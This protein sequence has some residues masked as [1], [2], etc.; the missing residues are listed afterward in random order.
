MADELA[1]EKVERI[2][3]ELGKLGR[4]FFF[5][6]GIPLHV[7]TEGVSIRTKSTSI[8][9]FSDKYLVIKYPIASVST[10]TMLKEGS[11]ITVRYLDKGTVFAFQSDVIGIVSKPDVLF[12]SY[13]QRIEQ[14]SLRS[15]GRVDCHLP[16]RIVSPNAT[17]SDVLSRIRYIRN[18]RK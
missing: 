16:C 13:P 11:R 3:F 2:S 8:G 15:A 7:E 9:Y 5:P 12:I 10:A 4:P 1:D 6:I 14:H 17:P 18:R